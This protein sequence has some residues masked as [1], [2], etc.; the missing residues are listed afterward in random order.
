MALRDNELWKSSDYD[1]PKRIVPDTVKVRKFA[2]DADEST[3]A[4]GTPVAFDTV[5]DNWAVWSAS[6]TGDVDEIKGFIYPDPVTLH[7]SKESL[8]QVML[9]GTIH[10]EDI[11]LPDGEEAADLREAL[12]TDCMPIGLIVDG[13]DA[14][15]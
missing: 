9:K 14:V 12:R 4:V 10:Y 8:V 11:V 5:N 6:A 3:L 2:A 15:R 7:A 13:L 1:A